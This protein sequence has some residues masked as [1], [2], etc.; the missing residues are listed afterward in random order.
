MNNS[1][2]LNTL[3]G[4][5]DHL[6]KSFKLG[7]LNYIKFF[8]SSQSAFKGVKKTYAPRDGM[9]DDSTKRG[10]DLV[11]S[12][13]DEKLKWLTENSSKYINALFAQEA[14]NASGTAK[15]PLMVNGNNWGEYSALELLRLKSLLD[16]PDFVGMYATLPTRAD[17]KEWEE[18]T[19]AQYANRKIF[20]TPM[21]RSVS[22][23]ILKET[24]ILQDPNI[25]GT[26]PSYKATTAI[27]DTVIEVGDASY[28]E[29]SGE[30]LHRER[31]EMLLRI[32]QLRTAVIEALKVANDVVAVE[33]D[34]TA[35]KLFNFIHAGS[36]PA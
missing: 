35:E 20:Q 4:I 19:D 22:K 16:L 14:T 7:L 30:I 26:A 12:T 2:K 6:A 36:H 25:S 34:L 31:A 13:V 28:Q 10:N 1:I 15:A 33:S 3:L 8:K 29:F 11:V 21:Q 17:N 18:C 5:T 23:S 24:Y 27:R 32:D 9:M